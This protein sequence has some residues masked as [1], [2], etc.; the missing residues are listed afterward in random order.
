MPCKQNQTQYEHKPAS[1]PYYLLLQ[2]IVSLSI[3]SA[4]LISSP[5]PLSHVVKSPGS[6]YSIFQIVS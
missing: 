4:S 6:I 1:L 3:Q 5:Q 2:F